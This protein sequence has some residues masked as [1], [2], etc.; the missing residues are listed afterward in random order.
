MAYHIMIMRYF[1]NYYHN[2]LAGGCHSRFQMFISFKSNVSGRSG[3]VRLATD[4]VHLP[5]SVKKS[6]RMNF[7]TIPNGCVDERSVFSD[8]MCAAGRKGIS[9]VF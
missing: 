3:L 7:G 1:V 5:P 8:A 9:A 4:D 2:N 6:G